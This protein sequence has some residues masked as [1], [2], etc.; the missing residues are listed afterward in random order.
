MSPQE[1]QLAALVE[2]WYR[3]ADNAPFPELL[4]AA[5]RFAADLREPHLHDTVAEHAR[6][7]RRAVATAEKVK[8]TS[9]PD[10]ARRTLMRWVPARVEVVSAAADLV[11]ILIVAGQTVGDLQ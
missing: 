7:L 11:A 10:D 8:A 3:E 1:P 9:S 4:E 5:D 6:R 2:F